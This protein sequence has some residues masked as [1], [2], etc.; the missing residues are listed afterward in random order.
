M[1]GTNA[2][3]QINLITEA[4]LLPIVLS[5]HIADDK[6]GTAFNRQCDLGNTPS[7]HD[8]LFSC[9]PKSADRTRNTRGHPFT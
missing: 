8:V 6:R 2:S 5:H 1:I 7:K 3:I 4:L 9:L